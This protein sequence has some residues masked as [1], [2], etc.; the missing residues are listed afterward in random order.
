MAKTPITVRQYTDF[1]DMKAD[2]YRYRQSRPL[3]ERVAAV[4]ELTHEGYTMKGEAPD[5]PRLQRTLVHLEREP[6]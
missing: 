1:D 4:S 5:V 6:R 3:C 2:E